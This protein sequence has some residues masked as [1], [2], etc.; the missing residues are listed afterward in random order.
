MLPPV[1]EQNYCHI[2]S[3]HVVQ[4]YFIFVSGDCDKE[5]E[6]IFWKKY[7][8]CVNK[9]KQEKSQE[10]MRL[11]INQRSQKDIVNCKSSQMSTL[12]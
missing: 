5:L 1:K 3:I 6:F 7:S 9:M 8:L 12:G 10:L 4:L 11:I 2:I